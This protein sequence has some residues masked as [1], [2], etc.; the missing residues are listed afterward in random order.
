MLK[1]LGFFFYFFSGACLYAQSDS[2]LQIDS[3]K[4]VRFFKVD[5]LSQ[6]EELDFEAKDTIPKEF[7]KKR[8]KRK[9]YYGYKTKKA[10][11]KSGY[12][13]NE[14]IEVFHYL[15]VWQE[16]NVYVNDIYWFDFKKMKVTE[17]KKYTPETAKILHGPYKKM[18]GGEIVEKGIF[19]VGTKHGRWEIYDKPRAVAFRTGDKDKT[20]KNEDGD[21]VLIKGSDT[22]IEYSLLESKIKYNRGW[23]KNAQRV[24]YDAAK[25]LLKEVIPYDEIGK[26]SGEYFSYFEDKKIHQHGYLINGT[27]VGVWVEYQSI[28]GKTRRL[29]E[30]SYPD[31][32]NIKNP[33]PELEKL[34]DAKG[35]LIFDK[36]EKIDKRP[37]SIISDP[38]KK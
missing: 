18:I 26:N 3:S 10:F 29:N 14:V 32:P 8:L 28:N 27:K 7:K 6:V 20:K 4:Y 38:L 25:T 37:K 15:K 31:F 24:Y 16:P 9:V 17:S 13:D 23:L 33:V 5:N 11:T 2:T 35:E 12:G 30:V 19:F 36:K 1:Y 22:L 34:W 21:P